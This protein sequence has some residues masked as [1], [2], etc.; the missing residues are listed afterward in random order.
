MLLFLW[1]ITGIV[2]L[3]MLVSFIIGR[4]TQ[5]PF[6]ILM[7]GP[8]NAG[9]TVFLASMY[10]K[11]S[12]LNP[13]TGFFLVTDETVPDQADVLRKYIETLT[14]LAKEEFSDSTIPSELS[15]WRF[16]CKVKSPGIF[17]SLMRFT[18]YDYAGERIKLLFDR[19]R[20]T[21]AFPGILKKADILLAMLDGEEVLKLMRGEASNFNE[22]FADYIIPVLTNSTQPV[23]FIITKWDLL[24]KHYTL[25]A[26]R[27]RLMK[28]S[29]RF[30]DF[31]HVQRTI[32][33]LRLIPVSAVGPYFAQVQPDGKVKKVNPRIEPYNVEMPLVS[34]LFDQLDLAAEKLGFTQQNWFSQ[35]RTSKAVA[36]PLMLL[37]VALAWMTLMVGTVN[38][39]IVALSPTTLAAGILNRLDDSNA[40]GAISAGS[41]KLIAARQVIEKTARLLHRLEKDLPES[42][43]TKFLE[44]H[45]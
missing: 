15:E 38:I 25:D 32:A 4:K 13:D 12:T 8:T 24:Q 10:Y 3:I 42:N 37:F 39:G 31:I 26:V 43:L 45:P 6:R 28:E 16:I 1:I 23:H 22:E 17:Y 36:G 34:I 40:A 14:D 11:L 19:G 5:K 9:K 41:G 30:R 18:Y 33:P 35:L 29:P 27:I 44:K 2:L 20:Y 21:P 7:L